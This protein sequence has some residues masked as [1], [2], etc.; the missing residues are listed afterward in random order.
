MSHSL[1][2]NLVSRTNCTH[3][4]ILSCTTPRT[5]RTS[6]FL[7]CAL[8]PPPAGPWGDTRLGF[9]S[10]AHFSASSVCR[11]GWTGPAVG[12]RLR[13]RAR[14]F[15]TGPRRPPTRTDSDGGPA[16]RIAAV[17]CPARLPAFSGLASSASLW[18]LASPGS[19]WFRP[20]PAPDPETGWDGGG[21]RPAA[22]PCCGRGGHRVGRKW[23]T[24]RAAAA[25]AVGKGVLVRW[26]R[27]GP[28]RRLRHHRTRI[29]D[30][31]SW[32]D[33]ISCP[34]SESGGLSLLSLTKR[35]IRL[36]G[37][38]LGRSD[39]RAH[40]RL[41]THQ[42]PIALERNERRPTQLCVNRLQKLAQWNGARAVESMKSRG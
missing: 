19:S 31:C 39:L 14:A 9:R 38:L 2:Y 8:P 1:W 28:Q 17:G 23:L 7:L 26:W 27:L 16:P 11:A 22:L 32:L 25:A 18:F 30:P 29:F 15:M 3:Y 40:C 5:H 36:D 6:W 41:A 33:T 10:V 12:A 35:L 4:S 21:R 13:I 37:R 42:R 24:R 34:V 20:L